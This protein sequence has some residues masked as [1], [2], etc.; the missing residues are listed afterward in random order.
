MRAS[1]D[2]PEVE[3]S[4]V[5]GPPPGTAAADTFAVAML[6]SKLLVSSAPDVYDAGMQSATSIRL[7]KSASSG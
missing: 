7:A 3:P 6:A 5:T 1:R 2:A 4:I